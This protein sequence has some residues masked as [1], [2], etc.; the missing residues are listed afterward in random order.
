M[1]KTLRTLIIIA[2][3]GILLWFGLRMMDSMQTQSEQAMET[4]QTNQS[5]LMT[6]SSDK[7]NITDAQVSYTAQKVF[8]SKPTEEVTGSTNDVRGKLVYDGMIL[9]GSAVISTDN[10]ATGNNMRDGDVR[11]LLG[12]EIT[13]QI[14]EAEVRESGNYD[15]PV[16]ITINGV[17]Q[18]LVFPTEITIM[19]D[20]IRLVGKSDFNMSEFAITPPSAFEIYTVE[21][22]ITLAF[23]VTANMNMEADT[24]MET[25]TV[26]GTISETNPEKDGHTVVIEGNDGVTYQTIISIP[27]LDA[28]FTFDFDDIKVGNELTITGEIWE[29]DGVMHLTA[30]EVAL[31]N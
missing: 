8:F 15:L 31:N 28:G 25:T 21:D 9:T 22:E 19:D 2:I 30:R 26:T 4:D 23:D 27:N 20:T 7:N 14:P 5:E 11:K 12:T 29:M 3:A 24:E 13:A 10:L 18:V 1:N 17:T 6:Q 16:A